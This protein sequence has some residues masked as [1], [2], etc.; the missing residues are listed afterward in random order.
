LRSADSLS[1]YRRSYHEQP[2]I[3]A[4]LNLL[5]HDE[6]NPRSL[7][8]QLG[9]LQKRVRA[10]PHEEGVRMTEEQRLVLDAV[11]RLQLSRLG[12]LVAFDAERP[13]RLVLDR[14]L[15]DIAALLQATSSA[16]TK[17]YFAD[18]RGPRQLLN[19]AE[20]AT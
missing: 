17:D 2:Q 7:A 14:Q 18:L 8:F 9:R 19:D 4:V 3:D 10:L 13:S 20:D 11:H 6:G 1:A 5:L 15:S 12:D 16:V